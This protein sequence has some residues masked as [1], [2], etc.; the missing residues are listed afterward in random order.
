MLKFCPF[1]CPEYTVPEDWLY[2]EARQLFLEPDVVAA[3]SVELKWLE[4]DEEGLVKF[5]CTEKQFSEERVR[6]GAKKLLKGR[7]GSTQGR[8][9]DFFKVTGSLTSVKRKEPEPKGS[10]KKKA[11]TGG[12]KFKKGK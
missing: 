4:P 9:D 8:L 5:M 12:G 2:K 6:N 10:A 7:Q 3:D 11:K 1:P